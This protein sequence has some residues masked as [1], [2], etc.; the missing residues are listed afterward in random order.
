MA[1]KLLPLISA[2][3]FAL[4]AWGQIAINTLDL[5]DG[6]G[7]AGTL[8]NVTLSLTNENAAGGIQVD[9]LFD[10]S[11]AVFSG[12]EVTGR[13]VGMTVEGRS[14]ETGRMRLVMYFGDSG[15]LALGTGP[16]AELSFSM[17]GDADAVSSLVM[18]SIVLS[19]PD[20]L[21]LPASAT[22]GSLTVSPPLVA[23]GLTIAALK[24]P[25]HTP[26]VMIMVTVTGGSGDAPIVSASGSEVT[27]IS[28]G[29]GVFQGQHHAPATQSSLTITA[30]DT[31]SHGTGNA[32]VILALP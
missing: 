29:S 21:A 25:G 3:V 28:L 11:V 24:N 4:P 5:S 6:Q 7:A 9:I 18:E 12:V 20:G 16:V 17:L 23:P 15:S 19:D 22:N 32:Q 13:G 10:S 14:L 1:L 2:L 30:T 8:A 31:N 26:I 27:L